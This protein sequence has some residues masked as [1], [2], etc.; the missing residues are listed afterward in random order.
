MT[1]DLLIEVKFPD[2]FRRAYSTKRN[3][4]KPFVQIPVA[5]PTTG[6]VNGGVF[7]AATDQAI[8]KFLDRH[9]HSM[10]KK[11][12]EDRKKEKER[13]D[14]EF[15]ERYGPGRGEGSTQGQKK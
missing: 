10:R 7:E 8:T 6:E 15:W 14:Q 4:T 5:D 12:S 1:V 3:G 9:K 2:D 11:D 13:Q